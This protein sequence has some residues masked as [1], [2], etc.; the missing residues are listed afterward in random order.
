MRGSNDIRAIAKAMS[1]VEN[2][3]LKRLEVLEPLYP[4]TGNAYVVGITGPPGAGKSSIVNQLIKEARKCS[5]KT[6]VLA[7]DPTSFFSSGALLG[8]RVRM[9]NHF[10]DEKIFIRS[11]G[12]RGKLGGIAS[13]ILDMITILDAAKFDVIFLETVGVGQNEIDIIF[14][15]D[16]VCVAL[17]PGAG[18]AV[19]VFKSGLM[20]IADIFILNKADSPGIGSLAADVV[21]MMENSKNNDATKAI[22]ETVATTALGIDVLWAEI[23]RH[24]DYLKAT[25]SL[26]I[27]RL[28]RF[29]KLVKSYIEEHVNE[30]VDSKLQTASE[31]IDASYS[32]GSSPQQVAQK[33]FKEIL[34]QQRGV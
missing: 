23:F 7:V 4:Y 2:A 18:D 20:E 21:K 13:A 9:N 24:L 6:A 29:R 3:G 28:C 12:S 5:L 30:Y 15:A 22:V 33:I 34:E 10:L 25:D 11:V 19:Q 27:K 1:Y 16:T 26:K 31:D 32:E 14:A 17:M 8:D